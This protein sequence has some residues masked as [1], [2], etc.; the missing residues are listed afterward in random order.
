MPTSV[1]VSVEKTLDIELFSFKRTSRNY[2]NL[3]EPVWWQ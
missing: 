2:A 3:Q 1:K